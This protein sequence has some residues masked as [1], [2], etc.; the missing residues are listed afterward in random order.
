[1]RRE[2]K[3]QLRAIAI[4]DII[5]RWQAGQT[6]F[7]VEIENFKYLTQATDTEMTRFVLSVED[8]VIR[9]TKAALN[10]KEID[11]LNFHNISAEGSSGNMSPL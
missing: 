5:A 1:M 9:Y 8:E 2:R 6:T 4:S 11:L 7:I 3:N 10:L